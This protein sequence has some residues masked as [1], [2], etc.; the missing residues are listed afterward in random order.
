MT[1]T[2]RQR[3]RR[4]FAAGVL[5]QLATAFGGVGAGAFTAGV[6]GPVIA[7]ALGTVHTSL[8]RLLGLDL[9]LV[10]GALLIAAVLKGRAKVMEDDG[11]ANARRGPDGASQTA[12][13]PTIFNGE[14]DDDR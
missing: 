3:L 2:H 9:A 5:D 13:R 1:E 11:L 14:V 4:K 7:Q 10:A 6:L 8:E 12:V